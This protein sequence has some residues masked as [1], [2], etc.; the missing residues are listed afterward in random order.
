ML[1]GIDTYVVPTAAVELVP[2]HEPVRDEAGAEA[3]ASEFEHTFLRF[4]AGVRGARRRRIPARRG[5]ERH[6]R[7]HE[8]EPVSIWLK[9]G[10]TSPAFEDS[11]CSPAGRGRRGGVREW[12]TWHAMFRRRTR[13][14]G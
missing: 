1:S 12:C 3:P 9:P 4:H 7:T 8:D 11:R 5:S 13:R 14:S 10:V 6:P 2:C